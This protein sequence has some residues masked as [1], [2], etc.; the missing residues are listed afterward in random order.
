MHRYKGIECDEC[1]K[2]SES[3]LR[4][5]FQVYKLYAKGGKKSMD[6]VQF[7]ADFCSKECM[8]TFL[9]KHYFESIWEIEYKEDI[10]E[11]NTSPKED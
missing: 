10:N 8:R 5:N 3:G 7:F 11:R 1:G 4:L 9:V 6:N 2:P